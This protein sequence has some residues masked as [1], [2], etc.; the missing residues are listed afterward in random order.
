VKRPLLL[1]VL[2]ERK[3][4]GSLASVDRG[5]FFIRSLITGRKKKKR[6]KRPLPDHKGKRKEGTARADHLPGGLL[7]MRRKSKGNFPTL[8]PK[9][10]L[11]KNLLQVRGGNERRGLAET[12]FAIGKGSLRS[13]NRKKEMTEIRLPC[14][15]TTAFASARKGK[16][17]GEGLPHA[18]RK[19]GGRRDGPSRP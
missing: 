10:R 5:I 1:H 7:F 2:E 11:A 15:C 4:K 17:K 12:R 19:K 8:L 18:K 13:G 3:K 6:G 16:R 14:T 9:K